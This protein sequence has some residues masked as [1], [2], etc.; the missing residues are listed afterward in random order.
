MIATRPKSFGQYTLFVSSK[1]KRCQV[2]TCRR[3]KK[4]SLWPL[5]SGHKYLWSVYL[6]SLTP[7]GFDSFLNPGADEESALLDTWCKKQG[8]LNA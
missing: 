2:K 4:G 7:S 1:V 6:E 3:K 5:C 8:S